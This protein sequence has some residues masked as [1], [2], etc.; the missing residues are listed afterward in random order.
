MSDPPAATIPAPSSVETRTE[1]T[2][3]EVDRAIVW[4]VQR[5]RVFMAVAAL[6]VAG[7]AAGVGGLRQIESTA[8]DR[9]LR[10]QAAKAQSDQ[11]RANGVAVAALS[12]R[13]SDV[14]RAIGDHA[15]MT[16]TSI[17]L[18]MAHPALASV[19]ASDADLRESAA[20]VVTSHE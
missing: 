10:R 6:V 4:V 13:M 19:L 1:A 7:V 15:E 9:V 11:V 16:R 20:R 17:R 3:A 5:R 8:E 2:D 18:L 14:E 12:G